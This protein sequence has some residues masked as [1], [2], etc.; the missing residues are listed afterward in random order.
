[1]SL[2]KRLSVLTSLAALVL[3]VPL[4]ATAGTDGEPAREPTGY[5]RLYKPVEAI[6]VPEG[7]TP[8]QIR[9]GVINGFAMRGWL[10]KDQGDG[11][12]LATYTKPNGA[13]PHVL[14]LKIRYTQTEVTVAYDS[15]DNL[16]YEDL[17]DGFF[18]LHPNAINWVINL[19]RDIAVQ[20]NRVSLLARQP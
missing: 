12:L 2:F 11:V 15:S 10:G 20:L 18:A 13:T 9:E 6:V 8:A 7:M 16:D 3:A 14:R 1:M 19:R 17:G 4:V 5:R